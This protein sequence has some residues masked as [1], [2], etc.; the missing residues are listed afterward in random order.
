MLEIVMYN[1][2]WFMP[3]L[4]ITATHK[5]NLWYELLQQMG[6]KINRCYEMARILYFKFVTRQQYAFFVLSIP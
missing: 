2:I 1:M 3:I 4:C 5:S 6:I